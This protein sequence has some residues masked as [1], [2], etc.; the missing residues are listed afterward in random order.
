MVGAGAEDEEAS[1]A[2]LTCHKA[3]REVAAGDLL[4]RVCIIAGAILERLRNRLVLTPLLRRL[5]EQSELL[6]PSHR[7]ARGQ[8]L[9]H[10][11]QRRHCSKLCEASVL[12]NRLG[13]NLRIAAN[14][15]DEVRVAPPAARR[16]VNDEAL[17]RLCVELVIGN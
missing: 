1:A 9:N 6:A 4:A 17:H 14:D 8:L 3:G 7:R 10:R 16:D 12:V 13:E 2:A 15:V 5:Q 11:A